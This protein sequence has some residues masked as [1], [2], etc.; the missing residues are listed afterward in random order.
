V[1]GPAVVAEVAL[2]LAE[3][4]RH[5]VRR[6][7]GLAR[8]VESVDRLDEPERRDLDQVVE[9]LVRAPVAARH[10]PGERQQPRHELLARGLVTVAVITDEQPPVLLRTREVHRLQARTPWSCG[11]LLRRLGGHRRLS[12]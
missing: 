10:P 4:R 11:R 9:R 1:H 2:E 12:H 8:R 3:H 6:E 5:G 7:G